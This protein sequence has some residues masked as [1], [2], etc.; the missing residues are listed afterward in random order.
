MFGGEPVVIVGGLEGIRP[1]Q[2]GLGPGN[3]LGFENWASWATGRGTSFWESANRARLLEKGTF[4]PECFPR[5]SPIVSWSHGN[6]PLSMRYSPSTFH[7]WQVCN[8]ICIC[9]S[10]LHGKRIDGVLNLAAHVLEYPAYAQ[11]DEHQG[12]FQLAQ[13]FGETLSWRILGFI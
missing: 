13:A 7:P 8:C 4:P 5:W 3:A 1:G 6:T 9:C 12:L 2:C 11:Q 10:G